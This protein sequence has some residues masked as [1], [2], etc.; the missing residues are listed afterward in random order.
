MSALTDLFTALA[1]K[2]RSKTGGSATYTPPQMVNAIDDVYDAGV[3]AGTPTLTGDAAVG[4]VLSGKTFYNNSTTRQTGSMTNN[5]A[6]SQALNCGDSYTVPEGYHNGNGTVTA[7]SLASQTGVDSGKTAIDASHVLNGYQGWV[8]GNKVSGSYIAPTINNITPDNLYPVSMSANNNY[9]PSTNGYAIASYDSVITPTDDK[10]AVWVDGYGHMNQ[11]SGGGGYLI[12]NYHALT[13]KNSSPSSFL[14]DVFYQPDS[15]G[16]AIQSYSSTSVTPS[17][18]GASF[19]S[20]WNRM[21]YGGYAYASKPTTVATTSLWTNSSPN[22]TFAAQTITLSSSMANYDE[23][24]ITFQGP[25]VTEYPNTTSYNIFPVSLITAS[26]NANANFC[27]IL[28][29]YRR[30][31]TQRIRR[32]TFVSNTQ[33]SISL[34]YMINSNDS[35]AN[36]MIVPTSVVGIKYN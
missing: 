20:G 22:G 5:G 15:D 36:N 34:A 14:K 16:Y 11:I 25:V 8:N 9:K 2:I 24:K 1:N 12:G 6:V 3:A 35:G 10:T 33:I 28:G 23:I 4:N 32:V 17:A 30:T 18:S 7:N 27:A 19:S 21:I 31:S 13:P 26:Q 29:G